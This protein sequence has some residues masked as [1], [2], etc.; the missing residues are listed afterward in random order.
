MA[1][2]QTIIN[3]NESSSQIQ[4]DVWLT[5]GEETELRQKK[6]KK[7]KSS[8]CH[9]S[10]LTIHKNLS[11][12]TYYMYME[13]AYHKKRLSNLFLLFFPFKFSLSFTLCFSVFTMTLLWEPRMIT[14][15]SVLWIR[16]GFGSIS[17]FFK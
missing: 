15:N 8:H 11:T 12:S 14:S 4:F 9:Y 10:P 6:A 7:K 5:N 3:R 13:S 16:F 2:W 1:K 17:L